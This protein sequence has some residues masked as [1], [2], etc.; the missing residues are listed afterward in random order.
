MPKAAH[1]QSGGGG[2]ADLRG[3]TTGKNAT[4][5][6]SPFPNILDNMCTL[7]EQVWASVVTPLPFYIA[8][9]VRLK[10]TEFPKKED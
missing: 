4:L 8:R 2:P 3:V 7:R 10:E 6:A 9:R 1:W 5:W